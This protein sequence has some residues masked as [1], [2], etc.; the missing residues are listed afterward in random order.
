MVEEIKEYYDNLAEEYDHDRFGN[1]YGA[2]L[3]QQE[4]LIVKKHFSKA[5]IQDNLDMACGT[6]RFL[7]FAHYAIDISAEMINVARAKFPAKK[8]SVEDATQ[9][10]FDSNQFDKIISFHFLMHF[11]RTTTLK[12]FSEGHR[13][14][15]SGG[16]FIFD[17]RTKSPR[18]ISHYKAD[19]WHGANDFTVSEIRELIG[20]KWVLHQ[21]YGVAFLPIHRISPSNRKN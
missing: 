2:F 1:S 8:L 18:N 12:V 11:D 9:T 19:N 16:K 6:G 5:D 17:I 3:D 14:L 15:K 7:E 4:K 13:I 20:E 21:Y 10:S